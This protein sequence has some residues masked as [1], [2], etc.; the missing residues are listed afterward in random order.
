M[1]I[2][3]DV[4]FSY[5]R[6]KKEVDLDSLNL[7][8]AD[9]EIILLCGESGCGK[10]TVT[11]LINGLIPHYYEGVLSGSVVV[12]GLD[13]RSAPLYETAK[14][15]GS[16]FQNPRSQFFNVDTTSELAFG[17][18]NLGL[19][20]D[21]IYRRLKT[22]PKPLGLIR[23]VAGIFLRFQAAKSRRLP[24]GLWRRCTRRSWFW[25]S[26]HPIWIPLP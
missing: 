4:Y 14:M 9:G 25:M 23:F 15:V 12:N 8:I 11:R 21:E 7:T 16:V 20:E 17:C 5:G 1:I 3:E 2:F 10:T 19:P 6:D 26:P 13:V 24:A 22:P 18:E